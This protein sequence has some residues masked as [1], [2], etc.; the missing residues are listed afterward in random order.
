MQQCLGLMCVGIVESGECEE[1][2]PI[3]QTDDPT[4]HTPAVRVAA[5]L[6]LPHQSPASDACDSQQQ[7]LVVFRQRG[8]VAR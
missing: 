4:M 7:H 8:T 2:H 3:Q 1:W 6:V 5:P